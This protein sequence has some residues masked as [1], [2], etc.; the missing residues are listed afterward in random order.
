MTDDTREP[1]SAPEALLPVPAATHRHLATPHQL[2]RLQDRVRRTYGAFGVR[3]SIAGGLAERRAWSDD[4]ARSTVYLIAAITAS[5]TLLAFAST[6][7]W[8]GQGE[9]DNS[10]RVDTL[11]VVA[12]APLLYWAMA[13]TKLWKSVRTYIVL[14]L[15]VESFSETMFVAKGEGGYWDSVMWP[16]AVAYYGTLKELSGL[17]GGSLPVFFFVTIGLLHRAVSRSGGASHEVPRFARGALVWFFGAVV[18]LSLM[19]IA[20]GGRIDWT[21]RQVV[22]MLEF[23]L[24]GLLFLHALRMPEDL[25]AVATAYVITAVARSLLVVFVYVVVCIPQGITE[26]PGKPEWCTTHSDT[27]LFVSA[28]VILF[29]HALE[30]ARA[31]PSLRTL[32]AFAVILVGVVL[33]N[34][35][36]AFVSLGVAPCVMVLALDRTKRK[37]K[38]TVAIAIAVPLAI[39]YVLVGSESDSTSP[40][41]KPAKLIVSLLDQRDT[42]SLSRDIEN[43]NLIYTLRQSPVFTKGFGHEYEYSPDQPPVDLSEVFTNYRLIAH[44]GVLW[45]WSIAGVIGFPFLWFLYPLAGTMALRGYRAAQAPLERTAALAALGGGAVCVVQIWGDQGLSSYMTLITFSLC[46]AVASRLAVRPAPAHVEPP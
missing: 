28:L 16:A 38:V 12:W 32:A 3:A 19:G 25:P 7:V 46:F 14:S 23:P 42:S 8:S 27:V 17:P 13:R 34:R 4:G 26:L 44:N 31:R 21:F 11:F 45:L 5:S 29:A 18:A 22:Y 10:V 40:L 36:L 6:P 24:V 39:A 41:L 30:G 9:W 2:E 20:R 15:F 43:D 35:R 37:R 1:D 33:N